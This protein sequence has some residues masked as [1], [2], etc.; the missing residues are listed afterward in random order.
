M[1]RAENVTVIRLASIVDSA[2]SKSSKVPERA[3]VG[4]NHHV[5]RHL[6]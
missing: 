6:S 1:Y 4:W 2:N 3:Y 5:H